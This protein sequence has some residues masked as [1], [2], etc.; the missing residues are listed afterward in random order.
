MRRGRRASAIWIVVVVLLPSGCL[1]DLEPP[2][3]VNGGGAGSDGAAG[4]DGAV[5]PKCDPAGPFDEAEP[6]TTAGGSI[7]DGFEQAWPRVS[8]DGLTLY[9]V[10]SELRDGGRLLD[11]AVLHIGRAGGDPAADFDVATAV[12]ETAFTP[13]D[14]PDAP[15]LSP[16]ERRLYY[17]NAANE[18]N[19]SDRDGTEGP[20]PYP[21][22]PLAIN[23]TDS[24][25]VHPYLVGADTIYFTSSRDDDSS[26]KLYRST[27]EEGVF[28]T[29][30]PM[31]I[32]TESPHMRMGAR[33]LERSPA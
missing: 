30:E 27:A 24:R 31:D 12:A 8:R 9:Y 29:A 21:G 25:D 17:S 20:F 13:S 10:E 4:E 26:T 14:N 33:G 11:P 22:V 2:A 16:D 32:V 3:A 15:F 18:L 28:E 6:L 7:N 23:A 5:G 1:P 19:V